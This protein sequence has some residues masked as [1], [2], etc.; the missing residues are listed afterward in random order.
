[1][2]DQLRHDLTTALKRRDRTAVSALRS[3]IAALDNAEAV[4]V[5]ERRR[6]AVATSGHIAGAS[7]GAGSAD[8]P[9]RVLTD[10]EIAAIV[11]D[12]IEERRE[13]ARQYAELGR[14]EAAER[15]IAEADVLARYL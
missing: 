3:A 8:V 6:P 5:V 11:A 12:Q 9:R 13:S 4:D 7:A 14:P 15:L 2:R 1:M 10:A